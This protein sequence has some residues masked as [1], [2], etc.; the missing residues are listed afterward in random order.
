MVNER[1]EYAKAWQKRTGGKVMGWFEPYFPEEI[2][3]AAGVLPVRILSRHEPNDTADKWIYASC[4]AVRDMVNQFLKGRYGYIDGLASVEGCQWM[5][6]A[7]EVTANNFPHLFNH[8]IFVPD[9]TDAPTSVDVARSELD[10]FKSRLEEWTGQEI[11]NEAL[12]HAID[13]YNT[14]RRLLRRIYELRRAK[15]TVILGSEAMNIVLADQLM[16]KAEM[17]KI[18]EAFIPEL[19]DRPPREDMIRL[20]LLG[21]ETFD[22]EL[23]E[24][25]E[26]LGANIVIDELDSG[27][28][29]FWNETYT[30]KDRLTALSLRY[31]GR[32][33]NPIKD[34]NWRRRPQH[35]F[36]LSEDYHV[37]GAIIAKQIYCHLHGTDNYVVWKLLRERNIPFHFFERDMTL[38]AE[39]T[40]VR[41]EAFLNMIRPGLTHL[42]GWHKVFGG[43]E[44]LI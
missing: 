32:P 11:T 4:Y 19:E 43:R 25:A 12:D 10:V 20:M 31:L 29:Y 23:E 36:E 38:P 39:D 21:S 18:L 6:D 33:H 27:S 7:F 2:A 30:Q 9:Y 34:N 37:D 41:L 26:S 15:N 14:N 35:I 17:N 44:A 16:D 1:H 24:L 22:T 13:V 28:S 3:Y 42:A 5:Y 40:E 8:F